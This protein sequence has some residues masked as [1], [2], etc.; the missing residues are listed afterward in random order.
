VPNKHFFYKKLGYILYFPLSI[1]KSRG[2]H[3][4]V[5]PLIF[6]LDKQKNQICPAKIKNVQ[7]FTFVCAKLPKS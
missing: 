4:S 1:N 7:I 6:L 2:Y 3:F 5:T